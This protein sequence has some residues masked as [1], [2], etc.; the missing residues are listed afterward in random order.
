V[1]KLH[2]NA[3]FCVA[4]GTVGTVPR[5]SHKT[6]AMAE[7]YNHEIAASDAAGVKK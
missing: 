6:D 5:S 1:S 4:N 3:L 2:R 7:H